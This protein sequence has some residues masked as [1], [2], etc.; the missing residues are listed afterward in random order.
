MPSVVQFAT[1]LSNLIVSWYNICQNAEM[2]LVFSNTPFLKLEMIR[3]YGKKYNSEITHAL[4]SVRPVAL[5]SL[6][7][8]K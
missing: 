3:N 7:T 6:V 8:P 1:T 4:T 2:L 5:P